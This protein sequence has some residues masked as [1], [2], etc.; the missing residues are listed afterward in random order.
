MD[1]GHAEGR[2]MR[3]QLRWVPIILAATVGGL[4]SAALYPLFCRTI[5]APVTGILGGIGAVAIGLSSAVLCG[6]GAIAPCNGWCGCF[7]DPQFIGVWA[8]MLVVF[9]LT[10]N[11]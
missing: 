8:M 10:A 1:E 2:V 3:T 9:L 5:G 11:L 6:F 7:R 4:A